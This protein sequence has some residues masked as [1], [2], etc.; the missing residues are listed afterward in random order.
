MIPL[1][2]ARVLDTRDGRV[3]LAL[4]RGWRCEVSMPAEG[5]G[6]VLWLPPEGLR[7]PRTWAIAPASGDDVPWEG[8]ARLSTFEGPGAASVATTDSGLVLTA[9]TL[10]AQVRLEPFGVTWQMVTFWP[11]CAAAEFSVG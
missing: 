3:L 6:R 4:E 8:R 1:R 2:I 9:P 7:E 11:Y 10:R 5:L